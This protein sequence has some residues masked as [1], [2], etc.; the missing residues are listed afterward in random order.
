MLRQAADTRSNRV[1]EP[2]GA[3][4]GLRDR[5]VFHELEDV[6]RVTVRFCADRRRFRRVH[7]GLLDQTLRE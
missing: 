5:G 6:Q 2:Q 3:A 1:V 7:A 4:S